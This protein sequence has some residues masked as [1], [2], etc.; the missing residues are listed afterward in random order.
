MEIDVSRFVAQDSITNASQDRIPRARVEQTVV[1][2]PHQFRDYKNLKLEVQ[3]KR[4][5]N[6]T[7]KRVRPVTFDDSAV[8]AMHQFFKQIG[9]RMLFRD[10]KFERFMIVLIVW[11]LLPRLCEEKTSLAAFAELKM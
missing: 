2:R 1:S 8:E 7:K 9:M 4:A 11:C 5:T 10:E 3:T 6:L